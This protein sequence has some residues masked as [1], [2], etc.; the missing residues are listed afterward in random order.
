MFQ[1]LCPAK[2]SYLISKFNNAVGGSITVDGSGVASDGISRV[3]ESTSSSS[4]S[5]ES[6]NTRTLTTETN[7]V[8][9]PL[10][11]AGGGG[12]RTITKKTTIRRISTPGD[13]AASEFGIDTFGRDIGTTA[14]FGTSGDMGTSISGDTGMSFRTDGLQGGGSFT[15][16]RVD[17][18]GGMTGSS[19][20]ID[21]SFADTSLV[22]T[23]LPDSP[24]FPTDLPMMTDGLMPDPMQL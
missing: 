11:G 18:S 3:S 24:N 16:T 15:T 8:D 1:S 22:D 5:S 6:S 13:P 12:T 20:L 10:D 23:T 14:D 21:T 7:V 4:R 9:S 17:T 2:K 19:G